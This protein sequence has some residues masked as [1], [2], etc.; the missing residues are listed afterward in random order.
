M[1][2]E[3]S[4]E[5]SAAFEDVAEWG[6]AFFEQRFGKEVGMSFGGFIWSMRDRAAEDADPT[7][8]GKLDRLML[9]FYRYENGKAGDVRLTVDEHDLRS[10]TIAIISFSSMLPDSL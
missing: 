9:Q 1:D 6:E 4:E 10:G 7:L 5:L 8:D 2:A 3:N